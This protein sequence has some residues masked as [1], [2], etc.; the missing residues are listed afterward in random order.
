MTDFKRK[1]ELFNSFFFAKPIFF[2]KTKKSLS[3]VTF[4]EYEIQKFS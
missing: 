2:L 1:S 4:T 3:N